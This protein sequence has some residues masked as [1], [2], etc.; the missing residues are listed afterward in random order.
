MSRDALSGL[1]GLPATAQWV[2]AGIALFLAG[3]ATL[4]GLAERRRPDEETA[5]AWKS[6]GTW[7][8]LFVLLLIVL[9]AGRVGVLLVMWV[10]SL[11]LLHETLRLVD[12]GRLLPLGAACASGLYAW[13]WLEPNTLF[14][15]ALPMA[16]GVL[17]VM[18]AAL[19]VGLRPVV[20]PPRLQYPA[21]LALIGPSY[22]FGST[23]LAPPTHLPGSEMGWFLLLVMLTELNDMAQSWWGRAIGS[24]PL[25]PV[26]SPRKTWEG[27]VGGLATTA[28]AAVVLCPA[29]TS[30][31]R[32][33]P[34]GL[35]LPLP[36]W[37]WSIGLALVIGLA[38]VS[39]DLAASGLKRA[40]GVKDSGT[41]LPG[42][43]GAL[44][45]LD[46]LAATAPV[47]FAVTYLLWSPIR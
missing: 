20:T 45:R 21:A 17:A 14:V 9:A 32:A 25:A 24:R 28:A 22:V 37:S 36:P 16:I 1:L 47:F 43:G 30:W 27:L 46:S 4:R 8:V 38:G 3:A 10:A 39:G 7:W 2:L 34:P 42:H 33:H 11:L 26:L 29:L 13:A 19:R 35:E 12:S 6:V 18:E 40:A 44:D 41:L 15:R 31:G 5:R 23:T